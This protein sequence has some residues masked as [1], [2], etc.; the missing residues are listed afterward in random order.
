V[1]EALGLATIENGVI[2]I[3]LVVLR[4]PERKITIPLANMSGL[5]EKI[6]IP[7]PEELKKIKLPVPLNYDLPEI[8]LSKLNYQKEIKI[9]GPGF[10]PRTITV[11]LGA[12]GN[13]GECVS[14]PPTGGNPCPQGE[15]QSNLENIKSI[16]QGINETSNKIIDILE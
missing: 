5:P 15:F 2:K 6:Q 11:D 13:L 16:Q 1:Q 3:P 7:W 10:Q 8:P 14:A 12:L 9:K 4:L